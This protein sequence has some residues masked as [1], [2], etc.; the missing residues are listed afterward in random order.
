MTTVTT[1]APDEIEAGQPWEVRLFRGEDAEGVARLFMSVYGRE[2]PIRAYVEPKRLTEENRS[3]RIIS[4]VAVTPHG[5]VVG[6]NAIFRSA[7]HPGIYESGAGLVHMKY[8]G[9]KGIFTEMVAHGVRDLAPRFG[10]AGVHG[11]SVCNHVF[12]Q[13]MLRHLGSRVHAVEVDLMPAAAYRREESADGRVAALHEH[14]TLQPKPHRVFI[15]PAYREE[16]D[17]I[18]QGLE[19]EREVMPAGL[20][21]LPGTASRIEESYFDF[22][23]VA[24]LIV[25]EAG[26]DFP[27]SIEKT[28]AS[29]ALRGA[30]VIQ[31]WLP[32][33]WPWVGEA[34]GVL[35]SR[36]YFLGGL[37]PRWFDTDGMMMQ[38]IAG[39]PD[40]EGIRI[41]FD[42]ARRLLEMVR[43]DW[44]RTGSRHEIVRKSASRHEIARKSK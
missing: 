36:G 15:P 27:V 16:F 24:R 40:W 4:S 32:L 42:R 37:L 25:R 29:L 22:A 11:E 33:Q 6:H 35:R 7:P 20:G 18:Y 21:L 12:T 8:R 10:L 43:E 1:A 19:D 39:R 41:E 34:V 28:E 26:A 2:Y 9:G 5:E 3:L 14:I 13:K 17:Y 30:Y 38:K 23:R 31:V 44:E